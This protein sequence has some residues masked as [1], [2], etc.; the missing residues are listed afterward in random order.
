VRGGVSL[1]RALKQERLA[2]FE[3]TPTDA[4]TQLDATLSYTQHFQRTDLDLVH[5]R[6]EPA[7]RRDSDFDLGAQGYCPTAGPEYHR[8]RARGF[9]KRFDPPDRPAIPT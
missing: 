9:L 7:E 8:W 6:Q 1:L 3:S 2:G 5:H 4:Y